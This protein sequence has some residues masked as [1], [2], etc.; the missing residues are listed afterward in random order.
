MTLALDS[1]SYA[2]DPDFYYLYI[3]FFIAIGVPSPINIWG[4]LWPLITSLEPALLGWLSKSVTPLRIVTSLW[5]GN[6]TQQNHGPASCVHVLSRLGAHDRFEQNTSCTKTRTNRVSYVR[7]DSSS[8]KIGLKLA[9]CT[10]LKQ[11]IAIGC[12]AQTYSWSIIVYAV[13]YS[14]C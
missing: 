5:K 14:T 12:S 9:A 8:H 7:L 3:E 13:A 6:L 2:S 11:Q 4:V 1:R 10:T